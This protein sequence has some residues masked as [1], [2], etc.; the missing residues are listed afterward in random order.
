MKEYIIIFIYITTIY[1]IFIINIFVTKTKFVEKIVV[2]NNDMN[3]S[4]C[5]LYLF[6][7]M[8][9]ASDRS[10]SSVSSESCL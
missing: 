8:R 2:H 5:R 7:T 4:I 9:K 3:A 6:R 1:R 10:M